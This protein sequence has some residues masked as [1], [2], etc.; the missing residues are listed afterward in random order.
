MEARTTGKRRT[1]WQLPHSVCSHQTLAYLITVAIS[2]VVI[3]SAAKNLR[4]ETLRFAQGD[5]KDYG[6]S[7]EMHPS[8]L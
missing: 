3:L 5:N 2:G 1:D 6:S 7:V 4:C 8:N